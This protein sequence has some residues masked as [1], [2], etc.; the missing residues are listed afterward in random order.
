MLHKYNRGISIFRYRYLCYEID[1]QMLCIIAL[2]GAES[3]QKRKERHFAALLFILFNQQIIFCSGI[4]TYNFVYA[5]YLYSAKALSF[6][7]S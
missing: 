1:K 7:T 5:F 3:L 6:L 4:F 2:N